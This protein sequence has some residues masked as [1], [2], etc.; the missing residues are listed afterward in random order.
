MSAK[1]PWMK[2][3]LQ[4]FCDLFYILV[5]NSY[6]ESERSGKTVYGESVKSKF[7]IIVAYTCLHYTHFNCNQNV[8]MLQRLLHNVTVA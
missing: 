2:R 8:N 5:C 1:V 4:L 7:S 6:Y 3:C